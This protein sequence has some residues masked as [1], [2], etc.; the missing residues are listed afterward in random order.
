MYAWSNDNDTE[1][2]L[3][4]AELGQYEYASS[5]K[6][7]STTSPS[8]MSQSCLIDSRRY[9]SVMDDVQNAVHAAHENSDDTLVTNGKSKESTE[10]HLSPHTQ[11][12]SSVESY[13]S[14]LVRIMAEDERKIHSADV[15]GLY[16]STSPISS[17]LPATEISS[18]VDSRQLNA[19]PDSQQVRTSDNCFP[20]SVNCSPPDLSLRRSHYK[21]TH[22]ITVDFHSSFNLFILPLFQL[23][24]LDAVD[25]SEGKPQELLDNFQ[26]TVDAFCLFPQP[27]SAID[28][29][30]LTPSSTVPESR[31]H[32]PVLEIQPVSEADLGGGFIEAQGRGVSDIDQSG[33][34]GKSSPS[35]FPRSPTQ[36]FPSTPARNATD[37]LL[38]EFLAAAPVGDDRMTAT[39][40]R[41]LH[42]VLLLEFGSES[43]V[44]ES[45][46][47]LLSRTDYLR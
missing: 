10:A 19:Y 5:V 18:P 21:H 27:S 32:S 39:V 33:V 31:G 36:I 1:T 38:A 35:Q 3:T 43:M 20:G 23:Q 13:G 29:T 2:E 28:S 45:L 37:L 11:S 17:S 34:L 7:D 42:D 41:G 12:E 16:P 6:A 8:E 15:L 46:R 40:K 30:I 9:Q 25:S 24:L 47:I 22:M 44:L 4:P 14:D 26:N